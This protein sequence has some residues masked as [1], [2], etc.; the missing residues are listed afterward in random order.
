M[1]SLSPFRD[2]ELIT[3]VMTLS[4]TDGLGH[5]M[6]LFFCRS[7]SRVHRRI[8][9]SD[10]ILYSAFHSY[11]EIKGQ[12]TQDIVGNLSLT[13]GLR[14]REHR[15]QSPAAGNNSTAYIKIINGNPNT[16]IVLQNLPYSVQIPPHCRGS[17]KATAGSYPARITVH[18]RCFP[19][20]YQCWLDEDGGGDPWYTP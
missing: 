1:T 8:K 18:N 14:E 19:R 6:M 11:A 17:K 5:R 13:F 9:T 16:A 15:E 3:V 12:K 20:I 10:F 7:K 4:V 2:S